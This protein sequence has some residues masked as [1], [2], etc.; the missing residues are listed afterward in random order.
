[1]KTN[2]NDERNNKSN[3]A[4]SAVLGTIIAGVILGAG[5][6][7]FYQHGKI[8][9]MEERICQ[10]EKRVD[11]SY[12]QVKPNENI[13]QIDTADVSVL[14]EIIQKQQKS[15]VKAGKS[16]HDCFTDKD[17]EKFK[18]QKRQDQIVAELMND[19]SF[20]D[21]IIS[22]KNM[23]P[24]KR[25]VLLDD[26]CAKTAKPTWR[27]LGEISP[28]GQ[29]DA[30]HEAEVLIAEAIVKKVKEIAN[31]PLGEIKKLYK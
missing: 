22:V 12:K 10:L 15:N 21:V 18:S 27:S 3:I 28:K 1:M 14:V 4:W 20:I 31:L 30:G 6:T 13:F 19:N 16:E 11:E 29:S 7:I 9:R 24:T 17:L 2:E 5:A 25:Q 8:E 23:T 26:I